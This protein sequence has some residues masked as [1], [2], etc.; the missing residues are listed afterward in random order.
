MLA[1]AS[2]VAVPCGMLSDKVGRKPLVYAASIVM[3]IVYM[4]WAFASEMWHIFAFSA[5]FGFANGMYLSVDYALGCE[6][7]PDK[8]EQA[9][10]ALGVWGVGAFIGTTVGPL[11]DGP[12]LFIL[13]SIPDK[14]DQYSHRGYAALLFIGAIFVLSSSV[15]LFN[16]S[17]SI[18]RHHR[19]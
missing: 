4:G 12:V 18:G 2:V 16:L 11:L 10:Q 19:G 14:T 7:I 13:G 9:A 1:C 8:D 15:A 5:V 17:D 6:A 3:A